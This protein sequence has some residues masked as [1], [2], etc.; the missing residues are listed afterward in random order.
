MSL[1]ND[2]L[3]RAQAAAAA[4]A[5]PM[6]APA[7]LAETRR[8]DCSPPGNPQPRRSRRWP[9]A[10]LLLTAGGALLAGYLAHQPLRPGADPALR[11]TQNIVPPAQPLPAP[12]ELTPA[13]PQPEPVT[14]PVA[15]LSLP[16]EPVTATQSSEEALMEQLLKRLKAEQPAEPALPPAPTPEPPRL[17][18]QGVTIGGKIRE[19]LINGYSVRV[20]EEV[21][22]AR[23][24]GIERSTVFLQWGDREIVLRMP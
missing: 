12:P 24:T 7:P 22:G 18:L 15:E 8:P 20:G 16:A 2:A 11:L 21:M 14:M 17:V 19:A 1:I 10:A 23:V 9:V 3:K 13:E 4:P 6:P 5:R